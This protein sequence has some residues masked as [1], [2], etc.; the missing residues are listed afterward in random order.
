MPWMPPIKHNHKIIKQ[1]ERLGLLVATISNVD[2][3]ILPAIMKC[4]VIATSTS[5]TFVHNVAVVTFTM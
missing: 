4:K 5:I 1:L 3:R 2:I